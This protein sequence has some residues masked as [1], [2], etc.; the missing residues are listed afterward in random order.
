LSTGP[1]PIK[2]PNTAP[3]ETA[4]ADEIVIETA[5][6]GKVTL[7]V[8]VMSIF[9]EKRCKLRSPNCRNEKSSHQKAVSANFLEKK[10]HGPRNLSGK[11][12]D[13]RIPKKVRAKQQP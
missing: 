9:S 11:L 5:K 3:S 10:S 8:V 12:R 4:R 13:G 6:T 2:V 1:H 7:V